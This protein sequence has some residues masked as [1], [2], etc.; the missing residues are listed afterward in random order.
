METILFADTHAHME[1][2][3]AHP[4][5]CLWETVMILGKW[6]GFRSEI[7]LASKLGPATYLP[8]NLGQFI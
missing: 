5:L 4:C 6:H 3:E 2:I 7:V 1:N 8:E